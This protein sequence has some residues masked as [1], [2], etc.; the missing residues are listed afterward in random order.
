MNQ[1]LAETHEE[2]N[3]LEERRD[4]LEQEIEDMEEQIENVTHKKEIGDRITSAMEAQVQD[5]KEKTE[6][7]EEYSQFTGKGTEVGTKVKVNAE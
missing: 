3:P 6:P 1:Q 7:L 5:I 4:E 2:I